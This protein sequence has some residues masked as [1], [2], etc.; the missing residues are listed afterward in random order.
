MKLLRCFTLALI[1]LIGQ[2]ASAENNSGITTVFFDIGHVL[3]TPSIPQA[4]YA[5]GIKDGLK[6]AFTSP[7]SLI[8]GKKIF[9]SLCAEMVRLAGQ[10]IVTTDKKYKGIQ[11][12]LEYWLDGTLPSSEC[13]KYFLQAVEN[14]CS[15]KREKRVFRNVANLIFDPQNLA[16]IFTPVKEM[17][18][19]IK[20]C[21]SKGL[22]VGIISNFDSET[23][24]A[25]LKK[26]HVP[27]INTIDKHNSSLVIISADHDMKKP[28]API[29]E[30][31][32]TAAGGKPEECFFIDDLTENVEVAKN[33]GMHTVQFKAGI[34]N[35]GK[36]AAIK[37]K[38]ESLCK[39]PTNA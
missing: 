27:A 19:L 39:S 25:I 34:Y 24:K 21:L 23:F 12:W 38:I 26:G 29:F 18:E 1:C 8:N 22:K 14:V 2:R 9:D 3:L 6:L 4:V 30:K 15:N 13:K 31:A 10:K 5:A 35:A 33:L 28:Y 37:Q 17:E 32:C 36:V 16:S 7:L 11:S 20:Y